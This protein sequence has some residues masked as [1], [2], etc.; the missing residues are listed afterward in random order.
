MAIVPAFAYRSHHAKRQGRFGLTQ[1][2]RRDPHGLGIFIIRRLQDRRRDLLGRI[3]GHQHQDSGCEYEYG[4]IGVKKRTNNYE[5]N[6]ERRVH[7]GLKW[8][9]GKKLPKR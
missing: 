9:T 2:I 6:C 8:P 1:T 5:N 7:K 3:A 4:E